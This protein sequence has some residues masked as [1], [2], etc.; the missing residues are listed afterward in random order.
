MLPPKKVRN[1][2]FYLHTPAMVAPMSLKNLHSCESSF[3][4][5]TSSYT[6]RQG[7][8]S[9]CVQGFQYDGSMHEMKG[10]DGP[11]RKGLGSP[12]SCAR[13]PVK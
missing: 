5:A 9:I 13:A 10:L 3:F 1:D 12:I 6:G 11:V 8:Q 7:N 2:C 4:P